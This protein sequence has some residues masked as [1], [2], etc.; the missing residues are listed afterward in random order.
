MS[1]LLLFLLPM[2]I[3]IVASPVSVNGQWQMLQKSIGIVAMHMQ[4]LHNDHIII[5]DRTDFGYSNISLLNGQCRH[6]PAE[7]VVKDD[8]TAHS[9]EYDVLSNTF[10]PLFVKTNIWCSSGS[11]RPDGSLVQTGGYNDGN[12]N[13]R[14]YS[15][16]PTCDWSEINSG[17]A[18]KRWYA[19]SHILPDGS[20]IV[21]GG[22]G[23][24]NYEF[25]P[26]SNKAKNIYSLPF[27]VETNDPK[28]E[29]NL[30][31]FVFLNVDGNLFIMANNK[32][33]LFDYTKVLLFY[34]ILFLK[35]ISFCFVFGFLIKKMVFFL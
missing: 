26:K 33:I 24:F 2:L 27:L 18:V 23:Q 20:Q 15:P 22:R 12:R 8:C 14:I 31:P 7:K 19:T 3:V 11:V 4:L 10:R 30:Y 9:V 6:D 21:I 35:S 29:N 13:I 32:S 16:C 5:F 28:Q 25:Y 1:T 34:F 17:L